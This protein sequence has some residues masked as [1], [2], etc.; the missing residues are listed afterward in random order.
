MSSAPA[1]LDP[2]TSDSSPSVQDTVVGTRPRVAGRNR[3]DRM[4]RGPEEDPAWARPALLTILGLTA[5]LYVWNLSANG[6]ANE[7]YAAAVKSGTISWKALLFGSIDPG[8]AITVDKPPMALW[9]M[10]LSGRVFGFSSWSMLLPEALMGVAS[11]GVLWH[12]VKKW[13]GPVAAVLASVALATTPIAVLMF[14]FNN[15]DALLT[16]LM[17]LAIW[18]VAVA[19]ERD[20][21][22][23]LVLAGVTIGAAVLTKLLAGVVVVPALGLVYLVCARSTLPKRI[24]RLL[25]AGAA[26]LVSAGW[27]FVLIELWPAGSRPYIGGSTDNSL[28]QLMFGY[29]GLSRVTGGTSG[30][31]GGGGA[32][33]GGPTGLARMFNDLIGGQVAWLIP[34]AGVGLL[35]GLWLAGRAPRTDRVRTGFLLWGGVTGSLSIVFSFSAGIFHPYYVVA[36][37]PGIA[38]LAGGGI[39]A[40]WRL[41]GRSAFHAWLLPLAIALSGWWA[42][43]LLGRTPDFAPALQPLVLF[44]A[45]LAA[46]AIGL[47]RAWRPGHTL[48]VI[49]AGVGIV[50][51]LAGP[52]AYSLDTVAHAS[53]GATPSAGPA[54]TGAS[55]GFGGGARGGGFGGGARPGGFGGG[56]AGAGAAGQQGAGSFTPPAGGGFAAGRGGGGTTADATLVAYL[57]AHQGTAKFLVATFTSKSSAPIILATGKPVVTIGGFNGGDPYPSLAQFEQLVSSGQLQY[58]V[59]SGGGGGPGGGGGSAAITAWVQ[60]HGTAVSYGGSATLYKL[61]A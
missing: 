1:T 53:T 39:V 4:W 32:N 54:L 50:S 44:G 36:L 61:T 12:L 35:A 5:V 33:F 2:A 55:G 6:M 47:V 10:G 17:L 21:A 24:V 16:L 45:L 30:P 52:T 29:N 48:A 43:I 23:P 14:R 46:L 38:A 20:R 27:F 7:F 42:S 3:F 59:M 51:L 40:L 13:M 18:G 31:G 25:A 37:A 41:G 11:V 19:I 57:E 15:P 34:I 49:A 58:I 9:I 56:A 60:A 26:F 28:L 22:L 8:N